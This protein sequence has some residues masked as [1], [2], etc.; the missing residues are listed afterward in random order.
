M[1]TSPRE[2]LE[3]LRRASADG[4]LERLCAGHQVGLMVA[5]GSTVHGSAEPDDLDLAVRFTS[6]PGDLLGL[7][8]ALVELTGFDEVDVLDLSRAGP[9]AKERS[10]D[11]GELL[12]EAERGSFAEAHIAAVLERMDTAWMRAAELRMLRS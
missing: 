7:I 5:F 8:D 10:L 4:T 12:F 1:S 9:V 2:A 6:R 3:T 11:Q